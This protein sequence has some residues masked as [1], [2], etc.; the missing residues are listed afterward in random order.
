MTQDQETFLTI[1]GAAVAD[2]TLDAEQVS[3]IRQ[4]LTSALAVRARSL[5][6]RRADDRTWYVH[7]VD[8]GQKDAPV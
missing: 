2:A 3:G 1:L 7:S 4:R 8:W 5:V 6:I